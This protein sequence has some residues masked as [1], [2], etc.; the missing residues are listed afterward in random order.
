MAQ[1]VLKEE[2][3]T[4]DER[5]P[6]PPSGT[7]TAIDR[8][9]IKSHIGVGGVAAVY[10][11]YDPQNERD[12]ALKVISTKA[13]EAHPLVVWWLRSEASFLEQ[14]AHPAFPALYGR[15]E[16]EDYAY[17]AVE[18]IEGADLETVLEEAGGTLPESDAVRWA[19]E[20][21]EA[22]AYLHRMRPLPVIYRDLKPSNAMIDRSGRVRL[23]DLGISV[24]YQ[25][26]QPRSA[27][28]TPGYASPEQYFGYSDARSDVYALGATLHHLLTGRD[29]RKEE[30]FTFHDAPPRSLNPAISEALEAVILKATEHNP[31]SRYQTAEEMKAALLAC[32]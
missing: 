6:A 14:L 25:S 3:R 16:T 32:L 23:I 11:A 29:P 2:P 21:S 28:G 31:L 15:G 8:F 26:G 20:V 10:R 30:A 1:G 22:L 19:I 17:I 5:W 18:L 12:V 4:A 7:P 27:I 24:T 13:G 9:R